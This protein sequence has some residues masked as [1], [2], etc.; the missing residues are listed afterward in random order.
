MERGLEMVEE[1]AAIVDIGGESSR[2]PM[3]GVAED[4]SVAEECAR[5]LPVVEGLRPPERCAISVDTVKA[6]VVA[7]GP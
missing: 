3:Y 1:G 6:E 4:V 2:P 7:S 5:V